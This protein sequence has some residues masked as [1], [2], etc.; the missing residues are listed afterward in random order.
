[1][2]F[3]AVSWLLAAQTARAATSPP[4]GSWVWPV[5]GPVVRGFEPPPTRFSPGHRGIDIAAPFGTPVHAPADGVVTFAG[6]V[7]GSL[8]V[9]IDHGDGY[10][11]TSSFLSNVL[12]RRGQTV[13]AGEVVALSGRGHPEMDQPQLHFGVR[14]NG[15]YVDPLLVLEPTS[16]VDLIRLAPLEGR[17]ASR[18]PAVAFAPP[19]DRATRGRTSE[20]AV[21]W[22]RA[23]L[24]RDLAAS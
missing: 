3:A 16:V 7:G 14:L 1:V 9:T 2:A 18:M 8:F 22:Q 13:T 19:S 11:S 15:E 24:L 12:V 5:T 20:R 10:R 6:P 23:F 17:E 21:A 4:V